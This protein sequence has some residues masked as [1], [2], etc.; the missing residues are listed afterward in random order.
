MTMKRLRISCY[1]TAVLAVVLFTT[2]CKKDFKKVLPGSGDDE[3]VTYK[4]PK[5]LYLIADGARGSSVRDAKTP[6]L[7]SLLSN[8]IYSWASLA[9]TTR[10]NATNW[11]DMLTGVLKE[12]H[13]V[14]SNDFT[15][16][17]LDNYPVIFKHIKSVRPDFRIVSFASSQLF[18]ENLTD[19]ADASELFNGDDNAVK[20]AIV[21]HLKTDT[22]AIVLGQFSAIEKAGN[23]YGFDI[24]Y[25]QYKQAI[26]DFDAQVGE[27]ITTLKTRPTYN[28]ENWLIV[29]TSSRGGAYT[30]PVEEDDKTLFSNTNANTFTI[31]YNESY[32]PTFIGRPFLG[33]TWS[34][35]AVRF[36]DRDANAV[37]ATLE[38]T[39]DIQQAL[40]FGTDNN[41]TISV[42]VKKG[43]TKNT[44]QGDYWYQWPAIVGKGRESA[45]GV[46]GWSI[47]LFYNGWRAFVRGGAGHENGNEIAGLDFS[48]ETW[49]DLTMVVEKK[50]DGNSYVRLY[51]DGVRGITN[52]GGSNTSPRMDDFQLGGAPNFDNNSK[53]II[54]YQ[55]GDIDGDYGVL[56]MNMAELK[57]WKAAL[58][59]DVIKQYSCDPT[60]DE[61]HPYWSSLIGYWPMV[62]GTGDKM[63]DLG[64]F[65]NPLTITGPYEWESFTSLL[66]SPSN[67][68][69]GTLV[70]KNADIPTQMLSW[71]NISR[72]ESWGL[73]GRVWIS[74]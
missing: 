12:K 53:L 74:N 16:N 27:I 57:I 38:P 60:M 41:F 43:K 73:D 25:P 69:L 64:P 65:A 24:K 68:N 50:A 20:D 1:F 72:Q 42:K 52:H 29:V 45:W 11:T 46:Q 13:G 39:T 30:L 4:A 2:S 55:P 54:G 17:K 8:S 32:K 9:D 56:N 61:S 19:G 62:D 40:N 49:H 48:G 33:A 70:P 10:N 63:E 67:T 7:T 23:T 47:C 37:K 15:D 66:C 26:D 36:K 14:T 22:A 51:T 5:V 31:F 21:N 34:G 71:F 58:P 28:Q 6:V 18:Q 3:E 44:S 35:A 59:E